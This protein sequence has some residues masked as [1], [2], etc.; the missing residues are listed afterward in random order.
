[1]GIQTDVVETICEKQAGYLL[2]SKRNQSS[3]HQAIIG[4]FDEAEAKEWRSI[5]HTYERTVDA[6]HGRVETRQCSAFPL[7]KAMSELADQWI[8]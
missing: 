8:G 2:L 3:L 7:P 5:K 4:C 1:M 6:D